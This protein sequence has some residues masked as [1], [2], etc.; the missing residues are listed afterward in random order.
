MAGNLPKSSAKLLRE[1]DGYD[2][3]DYYESASH[4]AP[5]HRQAERVRREHHCGNGDYRDIQYET[6]GVV[7]VQKSKNRIQQKRGQYKIRRELYGAC[8]KR[9]DNSVPNFLHDLNTTPLASAWF[10][11]R[12]EKSVRKNFSR[13]YALSARIFPKK[14]TDVTQFRS[15]NPCKQI[16]LTSIIHNIFVNCKF[17]R[18][19]FRHKIKNFRFL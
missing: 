16:F 11:V 18:L 12:R 14:T 1:H 2:K 9:V 19:I 4:N 17:F 8:R 6:R 15:K 13:F 7:L 10:H 5:Y 3:A